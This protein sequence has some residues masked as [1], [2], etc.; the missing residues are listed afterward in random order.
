MQESIHGHEVMHMM[1]ELGGS[2]TAESLKQAIHTRFGEQARFH[3]CSADN[4]DAE[5]LIQFLKAKGKFVEAA[6]GFNTEASR[7]CQH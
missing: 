2:F 1:L 5:A 4:M 6:D 3:T 7:I